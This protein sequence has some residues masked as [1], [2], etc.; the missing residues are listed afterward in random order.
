MASLAS[1]W[2]PML[3]GFRKNGKNVEKKS[4]EHLLDF[5]SDFVCFFGKMFPNSK[6]GMCHLDCLD[7]PFF[8]MLLEGPSRFG[9]LL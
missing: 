9:T 6:L 4:S 7:I 1:T 8:N 3:L 2:C 5:P